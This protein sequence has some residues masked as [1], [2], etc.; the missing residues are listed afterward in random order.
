MVADLS[1]VVWPTCAVEAQQF[2]QGDS[3]QELFLLGE[4]LAAYGVF[5]SAKEALKQHAAVLVTGLPYLGSAPTPTA[6]FAPQSRVR[7]SEVLNMAAAHTLGTPVGYAPEHAGTLVQD[8]VPLAAHADQ[9]TSTSSKVLLD[10]HTEAAFHP[11]LPDFLLLQCLRGDANAGTLLTT[12]HDL[13]GHLPSE[14]VEVL[15]RP[16]FWFAVDKSY[17]LEAGV[18]VGPYPV[19]SDRGLRFDADL[20]TSNDADGLIALSVLRDLIPRLAATVT[21]EAGQMLIVD[22]HQ[23]VHGRTPFTPRFNG[24]DR[25]VQRSFVLVDSTFDTAYHKGWVHCHKLAWP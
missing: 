16:I 9:Q 23:C 12:L 13:M 22:N 21:L 5:S 24:T 6:L 19:L 15:S 25:W 2:V 14:T 3:D 20:T 1:T 4:I 8:M 10:F 17:N 11:A 7:T 18:E